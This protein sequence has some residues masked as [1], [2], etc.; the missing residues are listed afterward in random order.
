[1]HD[2]NTTTSGQI[3]MKP[4]SRGH[5]FLCIKIPHS[6]NKK[7]LQT[8]M[9]FRLVTSVG[10]GKNISPHEESNLRPSDSARTSAGEN[11]KTDFGNKHDLVQNRKLH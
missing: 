6:I 4:R 9:F 3:N 7:K 2:K 10:Q 5:I 11:K 1:M 8:K